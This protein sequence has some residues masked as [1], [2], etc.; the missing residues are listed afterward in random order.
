MSLELKDL[1]CKVDPVRFAFLE[2]EARSRDL[3]K[4][5]IVRELLNAWAESRRAAFM[6]TQR[7]LTAEGL[8]GEVQGIAGRAAQQQGKP[9]LVWE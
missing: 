2:A 1:R 7:L 5:V 3:D 4:C 8:L 9:A 6:E